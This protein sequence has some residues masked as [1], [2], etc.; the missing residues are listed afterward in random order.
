MSENPYC[1]HCNSQNLTSLG[2]RDFGSNNIEIEELECQ[3][4]HQIT[5]IPLQNRVKQ[6]KDQIK[7]L[8]EKK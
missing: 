2:F 4:C 6:M 1:Y 7:I 5:R 8:E 3:D